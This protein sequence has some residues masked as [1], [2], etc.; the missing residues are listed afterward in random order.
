MCLVF[1]GIMIDKAV[2]IKTK[3]ITKSG[4][5]L[6]LYVSTLFL[7]WMDVYKISIMCSYTLSIKMGTTFM[8]PMWLWDDEILPWHVIDGFILRKIRF[9]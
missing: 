1:Y 9:Q 3:I 6:A 8:Q 2:Q 4:Y 7:T 5:N